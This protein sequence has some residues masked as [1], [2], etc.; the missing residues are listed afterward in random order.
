MNINNECK[1]LVNQAL[2]HSA[3]PIFIVD[4]NSVVSFANTGA[5]E[6]LNENVDTVVGSKITTLFGLTPNDLASSHNEIFT[7]TLFNPLPHI[8]ALRLSISYVATGDQN[9]YVVFMRDITQELQTLSERN[10]LSNTIDQIGQAILV[11]S[12][13]LQIIQTNTQF[14]HL[15]GY[16]EEEL[17]GSHPTDY[18]IHEQDN[19]ILFHDIRQHVERCRTFDLELTART[20]F[21]EHITLDI[22]CSPYYSSNSEKPEYIIG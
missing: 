13:E 7:T 9:H 14:Q 18:L 15:V 12:T 19:P 16:S 5:I 4:V 22:Q 17:L 20:K 10:L 6:L 11:L 1:D 3:L 21:G 2:G 8:E